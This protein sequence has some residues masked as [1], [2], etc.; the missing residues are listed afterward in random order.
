MKIACHCGSYINDNIDSLPHKAHLLPDQ[1]WFNLCVS[2]DRLQLRDGTSVVPTEALSNALDRLVYQC[3]ACGRLY[4]S[5]A[6]AN[7]YHCFVPADESVP[8]E[9]LRGRDDPE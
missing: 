4:I 7:K 6:K 2:W 3:K 5:G 9:I 8:K 1:D